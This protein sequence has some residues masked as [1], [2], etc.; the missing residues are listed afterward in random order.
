MPANP[1]I[2][3]EPESRILLTQATPG[4]V[5]SRTIETPL[6]AR[7]CPSGT[8]LSEG[9]IQRLAGRGIKR[10]WVLGT[11]FPGQNQKNWAEI[12]RQV[13]ERFQRVEHEP[14]LMALGK[15]IENALAKRL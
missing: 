15:M 4:M 1:A 13:R 6:R 14:Y 3:T 2:S 11:P 12:Q 8:T 10:I 7:L 9:L 5:L